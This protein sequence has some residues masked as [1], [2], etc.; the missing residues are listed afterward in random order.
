MEFHSCPRNH[1]REVP[2]AAGSVLCGPCIRQLEHTLRALPELHQECLHHI[3]TEPRR[4]N[5][6]RVSGSRR[7]DRLNLSAIDARNNIV[8]ILE[9]WS[10]FAAERLGTT[11]VIRSVPHLTRFLG[12]HL[13]WLT[14][15][16]PAADFADE[17][18]DLRLELLNAIDPEAGDRAVP[19][20]ACVVDGCPGTIDA[21]PQH[22][23]GGRTSVGC[24]SGHSWGI[25]EWLTLRHLLDQPR[26]AAV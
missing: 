18:E 22:H 15:Q 8:A 4:R 9:S 16:P 7:R 23:N 12:R 1:G 19:T 5:P 25:R 21:S 13:D 11:A 10:R 24:S 26:T 2:A 6:T 3:Q 20:R 17:I 14:A